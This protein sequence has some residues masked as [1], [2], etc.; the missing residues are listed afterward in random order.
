MNNGYTQAGSSTMRRKL[1]CLLISLV[2][3]LS[4]I[5]TGIA[6]TALPVTRIGIV[7][8]GELV[9]HPESVDVFKRELQTL[10]EG[11]FDIRFPEERTLNGNWNIDGVKAALDT[12]LKASDVDMILAIGF[13]ATNEACKRKGLEKPVFCPFVVDDRVQKLPVN[14]EGSGVKNLNYIN[15]QKSIDKEIKILREIAPFK[16]LAIITDAFDIEAL[17][18]VVRHMKVSAEEKGIRL[19]FVAYEGTVEE[20]LESIPP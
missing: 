17:P 19:H 20:T 15:A 3:V 18:D 6:E 14:G 9:R 7:T 13:V 16:N 12:L 8:D 4:F 11:E 1:I 2:T 5:S 10:A